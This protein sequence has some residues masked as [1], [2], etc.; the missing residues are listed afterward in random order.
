MSEVL[1]SWAVDLGYDGHTFAPLTSP[2]SR[3]PIEPSNLDKF[4]HY[5]L[6]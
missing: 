3:E 2:V 6:H 5:L 1:A 4:V